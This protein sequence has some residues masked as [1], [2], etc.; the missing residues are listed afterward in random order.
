[1]DKGCKISTSFIKEGRGNTNVW[2][3]TQPDWLKTQNEIFLPSIMAKTKRLIKWSNVEHRKNWYSQ[4]L[5][6]AETRGIL[7]RQVPN[8]HEHR[9]RSCP[10][11]QE[12]N[13]RNLSTKT[14]TH[15]YINKH[16]R[17]L[18]RHPIY[19]Y[20]EDKTTLQLSIPTMTLVF[21]EQQHLPLME[22]LL[23]DR[24]CAKPC[25]IITDPLR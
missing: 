24:H 8:I 4:L 18:E 1:M 5:E 16:H 10:F 14:P 22:F 9:I 15:R 3:D 2:R 21:W 12:F 25:K 23:H 19:I 20:W 17:A 11:I 6:A 7:G 13:C